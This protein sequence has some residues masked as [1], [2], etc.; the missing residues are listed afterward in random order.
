MA[1]SLTRVS[2]WK[3]GCG[4][5]PTN[6][7][8]VAET[9]KYGISGSKMLLCELCNQYVDFNRGGKYTPHFKHSKR[10]NDCI[11]KTTSNDP[12]FRE[13]PLGFSLP[14]KVKI[15][16]GHLEILIGFLPIGESM[17]ERMANG[18]AKLSI[19]IG[20]K[21]IKNYNIDHSRF[22]PDEVS[23]L[24]VGAN[25]AEQY[26]I[27]CGEMVGKEYWPPIA[28][29]I[30]RGGSLFNKATGK[31][32]PRNANVVVGKEYLLITKRSLNGRD[33]KIERLN[34]VGDYEL[35]IVKAIALTRNAA[36]FFLKYG[37]R[38]TD[39]PTEITQIYP[40]VFR[41]SH[42]VLFAANKLWFHK[43]NGFIDTYPASE[44]KGSGQSVFDIRG[45]TQR[46]LSVSR[47]EGRTSVLRYLMLRKDPTDFHKAINKQPS[48]TVTVFDSNGNEYVG[49]QYDKLPRDR[50]LIIT[51]EFD[52]FVDVTTIDNML[53][54]R[55]SL[56]NGEKTEIDIAYNQ[57]Y[58][59][60]L[61]LDC[62]HEIIFVKKSNPSAI[63]DEQ[64]LR[65]LKSFNSKKIVIQ[66]SFGVI[67]GKLAEM[68]LSRLWV[69]KQIRHGQIDTGAK[70]YLMKF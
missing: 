26:R 70:D 14:I 49:G 41:S 20:N 2:I 54:Y 56:K 21:I 9:Y 35:C 42:Y 18:G 31:R 8:V 12:Y 53:T 51:T 24:S 4:W 25:I 37:A 44:A 19:S 23:Y 3:E 40:F 7:S 47:F 32:L 27:D 58:R 33:I 10:S 16:N 65:K 39:S 29:V 30:Y 43:T 66:H 45:L 22:L 5:I 1:A 6:A 15:E 50:V 61:G 28:E 62:L 52:G 60:F 46:I 48:L 38:L 57:K 11:E 34:S 68:P 59:I 13:N 63:T 36:D 67:A 64:L 55:H 69:M 17:L